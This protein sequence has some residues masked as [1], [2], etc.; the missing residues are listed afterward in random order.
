MDIGQASHAQGGCWEHTGEPYQDE[1]QWNY[2]DALSKGKGGKG[3][4]GY[5]KAIGK[6]YP[7]SATRAGSTGTSH[8]NARK[9][10]TKEREKRSSAGAAATQVTHTGCAWT[11]QERVKAS[12][13][14]RGMPREHTQLSQNGIRG[15]TT[16]ETSD[17]SK[18]L[19][20]QAKNSEK[21]G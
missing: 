16:A 6:G 2:L 20:S 7:G 21:E 9:E 3:K 5:G 10:K 11:E 15:K 8:M 19:E 1:Y 4:G 18:E 13:G 17:K 14:A 12:S